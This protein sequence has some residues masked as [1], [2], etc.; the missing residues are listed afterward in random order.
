MI[1][2][3]S[4]DYAVNLTTHDFVNDVPVLARVSTATLGSKLI[5]GGAFTSANPTFTTVTGDVSELLILYK[6]TG[7]EATSSLIAYYDT[8]S[9]GMPITPN[10][11]NI[12]CTVNASG[13]FA[14]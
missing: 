8:F 9:S 7:T 10:G 13:W 11:G 1:L 4:A 12:V 2:A 14:L 3:D 6:D 5:S